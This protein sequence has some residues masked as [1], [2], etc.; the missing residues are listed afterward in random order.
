MAMRLQE[1]HPAL[2]HFPIALLPTALAADA[3]GRFA[4]NPQLSEIGRRLMP[5]AAGS[6]V[7]AGLAGL[8]AQEASVVPDGPAHDQLTTHRNLNLG[9]IGLATLLAVRR[10]GRRRASRGYLVAGFA[11]LG[12]MMYSA[13]LGGKLVYEHGLGVEPAGGLHED[14]APELRPDNLGEVA[15]LAAT[16]IEHGAR[17]AWEHLRE[18]EF[19]PTLTGR[20]GSPGEHG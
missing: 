13:S 17:H 4:D 2:V 9:L 20:G 8:I 6:T 18:G 7:L 12:A 11:G 1:L 5:F 19:A 14:Q 10:S 16:Q 15:R 3:V